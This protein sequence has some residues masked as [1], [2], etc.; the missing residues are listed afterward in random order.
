MIVE[1]EIPELHEEKTW[2]TAEEYWQQNPDKATSWINYA[3]TLAENGDIEKAHSIFLEAF[4]SNAFDRKVKLSEH[5]ALFVS[6][7]LDYAEGAE[8]FEQLISVRHTSKMVNHRIKDCY[9]NFLIK[10]EQLDEAKQLLIS[11]AEELGTTKTMFKLADIYEAQG[12][13]DKSIPIYEELVRRSKTNS[14]AWRKLRYAEK[15]LQTNEQKGRIVKS[16]SFAPEH[17]VAGLSILQNFGNVLN[18]KY[19]N[20]GVAFSIQQIGTKIVM[21]IEHP[22]G[23]K[24]VVE[25][26][27]TN[28]GL[29]VFEKITPEQYTH[30]PVEI[31]DLKRQIIQYKGELEW[32]NE[33]KM[34]I[35]GI[36]AR[37]DSIILKQEQDLA[38]FKE[39]F[40]E[41]LHTNN[42][43]AIQNKDYVTTLMSMLKDQ[44]SNIQDLIGKLVSSAE[45]KDIEKVEEFA[46]KILD[47]KP[48]VVAKIKEFVYVTA[49]SASGN[50]PAWIDFLSKTL[51]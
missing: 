6:R 39:K 40:G 37:Q 28:Y 5:Y 18:K 33:K 41:V 8:I 17:H 23:D 49:A 30:D 38:Y 2:P 25:E 48:S 15:S 43:L 29:V 35:E 36:V 7:Y 22:E 31:M 46:N 32:A 16:I 11:Q 27:L 45:N 50:A 4:A 13:F 19:P 26:Y 44:D 51:P 34:M 21:T 10:N 9:I 14:E 42:Q 1:I 12:D 3:E 47:E 24:E 20:G